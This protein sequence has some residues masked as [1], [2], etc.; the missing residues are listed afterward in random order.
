MAILPMHVKEAFNQAVRHALAGG[1][2]SKPADVGRVTACVEAYQADFHVTLAQLEAHVA[3]P[4]QLWI[5]RDLSDLRTLYNALREGETTVAEAFPGEEAPTQA[6]PIPTGTVTKAEEGI[7]GSAVQITPPEPVETAV[8]RRQR[9]AAEPAEAPAPE[10]GSDAE[11]NTRAHERRMGV[12]DAAPNPA[13]AA[14][15]APPA[16]PEPAPAVETPAASVPPPGSSLLETLKAEA[17]ACRTILDLDALLGRMYAP[18]GRLAT[19]SRA[20]KKTVLQIISAR[21]D[22]LQA[23]DTIR[24]RV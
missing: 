10:P 20:D 22:A 2:L 9:K 14:P 1:E 13:P 15:S 24:G 16:T 18:G 17:E 23:A 5:G 7:L 3:K 19:A 21:R 11:Y 4:R 8:G 6:T 12:L